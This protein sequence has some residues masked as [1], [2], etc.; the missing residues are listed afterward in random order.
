MVL[1][2]QQHTHDYQPS[3]EHWDAWNS[4]S[5][6]QQA[7]GLYTNQL[8]SPS[9]PL[10]SPSMSTDGMPYSQAPIGY[11]HAEFSSPEVQAISVHRKSDKKCTW[12]GCGKAFQNSTRLSRHELT[13]SAPDHRKCEFCS[14]LVTGEEGLRK[15]MR[16]H[17]EQ[18]ERYPRLEYFKEAGEKMAARK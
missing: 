3:V 17:F 4:N 2:Y 15:H 14:A 16:R 12:P 9:L 13:H 11:G 6:N 10:S 8:I 1:D 5:T 7:G 18:A